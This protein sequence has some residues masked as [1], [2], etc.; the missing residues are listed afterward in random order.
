LSYMGPFS[1]SFFQSIPDAAHWSLPKSSMCFGSC[2]NDSP[3]CEAR[4][5]NVQ[6]SL[7]LGNPSPHSRISVSHVPTCCKV[8]PAR[9]RWSDGVPLRAIGGCCGERFR[10]GSGEDL[11]SGL[12]N[13]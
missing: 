12:G 1:F 9:P 4:A 2:V 6:V 13:G 3:R 8:R 5:G 7:R 10:G 11:R